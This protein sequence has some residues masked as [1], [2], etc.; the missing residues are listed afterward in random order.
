M[1]CCRFYTQHYIDYYI[2]KG[3]HVKTYI[4]IAS[5][6]NRWNLCVPDTSYWLLK[7]LLRCNELVTNRSVGFF[8]FD[9]QLPSLC[10]LIIILASMLPFGLLI[11]SLIVLLFFN[12]AT[13]TSAVITCHIVHNFTFN[14]ITIYSVTVTGVIISICVMI[15][16]SA[17]S[18]DNTFIALSF[19]YY[20]YSKIGSSQI[21]LLYMDYS[22]CRYSLDS[23]WIQLFSFIGN[24][25]APEWF[26]SIK[27]LLVVNKRKRYFWLDD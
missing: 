24:F 5:E 20:Y 3:E 1:D 12:N 2:S 19:Y 7:P 6:I 10:W 21:S 8:S 22:P 18:G 25:N 4:D 17:M 27:K 26:K 9:D 16:F 15:T 13:V 11:L 14:G 23:H